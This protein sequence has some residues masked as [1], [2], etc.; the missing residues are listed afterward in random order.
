MPAEAG[1]AVAEKLRRLLRHHRTEV[2]HQ[3]GDRLWTCDE[4]EDA[5]R[6]QE[7]RRDRDERAVGER[8][9][10]HRHVVVDGVLA[11]ALDDL[12]PIT[13]RNGRY[14]RTLGTLLRATLTLVLE[15]CLIRD[16]PCRRRLVVASLLVLCYT[17]HQSTP[18]FV[19]RPCRT[20]RCRL[21]QENGS[22]ARPAT[23]ADAE[24]GS[25]GGLRATIV[26]ASPRR[27]GERTRRNDCRI[28]RFAQT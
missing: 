5:E 6:H 24:Q 25:C 14:T 1:E 10:D 11:G 23:A 7:D 9:R 12:E 15:R 20:G 27:R 22:A 2:I 4:G 26:A 13:Q 28:P 21:Q 16:R 17:R 18:S 3:A 8:L 19:I